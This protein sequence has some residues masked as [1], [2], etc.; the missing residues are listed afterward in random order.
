MKNLFITIATT[1][2]LFIAATTAHAQGWV[3]ARGAVDAGGSRANSV[4]ADRYGNVYVAGGFAD[5][6]TFGGVTITSPYWGG[7]VF[8]VKY[9]SL[10]NVKWVRYAKNYVT[11]WVYVATDSS[12]GVYFTGAYD[13]S[14]SFGGTTLTCPTSAIY[15]VKYD[16]AGNVVWAKTVGNDSLIV[17][18]L[19][20]GLAA[21]RSCNVY[22]AG[23]FSNTPLTLT[24]ASGTAFT[25]RPSM[26]LM[27]FDSSG[28][29][30]W[31]VGE[32]DTLGSALPA[33][34][35]S[36]AIDRFDHIYV[37][38]KCFKTAVFDTI[39]FAPL[40]QGM[41]LVRYDTAGH[42]RWVAGGGHL[43]ISGEPVATDWGMAVATGLDGSVYVT[44]QY[45]STT[46]FADSTFGWYGEQIFLAK[47][48]SSG[49]AI[50]GR[51]T[52]GGVGRQFV[53]DVATD[54]EGNCFLTGGIYPG[55]TAFGSVVLTSSSS[56]EVYLMEYDSSG[57]AVRGATSTG[58]SPYGEG[59]PYGS[60]TVDCSEN[61]YVAGEF[62]S[63][64][65]L[66]FGGCLLRGD[67]VNMTMFVAKYSN[68]YRAA[69]PQTVL[70]SGIGLYPNPAKDAIY[71]E[72]SGRVS[73]TAIAVY[74]MVGRQVMDFPVPAPAPRLL[75]IRLPPLADGVYMLKATEADGV[76]CARFVLKR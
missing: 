24:S 27:K 11:L 46:T 3:W 40:G 17:D 22:V 52:Y 66:S 36:L 2:L 71:L 50:W 64:T 9:D 37:T 30:I 57:N 61:I 15:L 8:L 73:A 68:A 51:S 4:T 33:E 18:F 23:R 6:I 58:G 43:T 28:N 63:A 1:M 39:A 54:A 65:T 56:G 76:E 49:N 21:D 41:F 35:H 75:Q 70:P 47:Y 13:T 53:N 67:T 26:F 19:P 60:I 29:L 31:T 7:N 12:G 20:F 16:T 48:D 55:S 10:G 14:I 44:G 5:S 38:G 45:D 74:D 72:L 25:V 69:T 62:Y 34:Q 32:S 59:G 42:A